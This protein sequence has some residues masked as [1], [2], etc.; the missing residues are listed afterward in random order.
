MR[1][2]FHALARCPGGHV[3]P[4]V[5]GTDQ[6]GNSLPLSRPIAPHARRWG[7]GCRRCSGCSGDDGPVRRTGRRCRP[8]GHGAR[9]SSSNSTGAIGRRRGAQAPAPDLIRRGGLLRGGEGMGRSRSRRPLPTDSRV[10]VV[11]SWEGKGLRC[12]MGRSCAGRGTI[13]VIPYTGVMWSRW[14]PRRWDGAQRSRGCITA[15]N[16]ER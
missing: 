10:V 4:A 2:A 12:S 16:G 14:F 6:L 15:R 13:S 8:H 9:T 7:Q 1:W 11:R 3:D 5:R